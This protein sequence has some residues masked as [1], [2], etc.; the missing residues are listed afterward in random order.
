MA[1]KYPNPSTIFIGAETDWPAAAELTKNMYAYVVRVN[2]CCDSKRLLPLYAQVDPIMTIMDYDFG[3]GNL[4][5]WHNDIESAYRLL[6][7][8]S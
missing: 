3:A 6:Y 2:A 7:P 1:S 8:Y 4:E 5:E